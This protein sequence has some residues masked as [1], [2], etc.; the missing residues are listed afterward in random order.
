MP[1]QPFLEGRVFDPDRARVMGIVFDRV[2]ATL[3]LTETND[4]LTRIVARTVIDAAAGEDRD[5]DLLTAKV[6]QQFRLPEP[7]TAREKPSAA[8]PHRTTQAG[9]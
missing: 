1:I 4:F 3:G 9:A 5:P 2:C 7:V 8:L 6:I